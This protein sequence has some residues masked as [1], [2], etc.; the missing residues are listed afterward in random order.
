MSDEQNGKLTINYAKSLT[1]QMPPPDILMLRDETGQP[2]AVTVR[3]DG[4]L[5]TEKLLNP[6][7]ENGVN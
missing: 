6:A 4:Q 3:P 7:V 5:Q 2:W 1:V